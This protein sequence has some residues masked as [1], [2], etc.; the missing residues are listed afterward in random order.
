MLKLYYTHGNYIQNGLNPYLLYEILSVR[1]Q[2]IIK[3]PD[4][5]LFIVI[6]FSTTIYKTILYFP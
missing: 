3:Q 4:K 5:F 1:F 2:Q 6:G